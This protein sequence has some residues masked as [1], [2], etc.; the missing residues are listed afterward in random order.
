MTQ[1][2]IWYEQ[3]AVERAGAMRFYAERADECARAQREAWPNPNE[4]EASR[5]D[6]QS[7]RLRALAGRME[8]GGEV[9]A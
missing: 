4:R 3:T 2:A 5:Q 1:A 9:L 7:A 8:A 6:A